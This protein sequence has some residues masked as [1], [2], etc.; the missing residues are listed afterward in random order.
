M[1]FRNPVMLVGLAAALSLRFTAAI[2]LGL[3]CAIAA[4][5][6][7]RFMTAAERFRVALAIESNEQSLAERGK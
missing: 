1:T 3:L 4:S 7:I 5:L 6:F 2:A